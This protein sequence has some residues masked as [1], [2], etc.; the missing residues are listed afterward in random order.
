MNTSKDT[1]KKE[2]IDLFNQVIADEFEFVQIMKANPKFK[3]WKEEIIE[4]TKS[5]KD[6]ENIKEA[7]LN[8]PENK[9]L[10]TL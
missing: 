9:H 5:I 3:Y 6:M 2:I 10:N 8:R 7:W 1:K 4:A